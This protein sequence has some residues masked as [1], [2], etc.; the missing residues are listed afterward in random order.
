MYVHVSVNKFVTGPVKTNHASATYMRVYFAN[1]F[2]SKINVRSTL[3]PWT[4]EDVY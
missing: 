4:I 3:F 1:I 2:S